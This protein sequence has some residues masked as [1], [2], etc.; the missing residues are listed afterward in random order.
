MLS[1]RFINYEIHLKKET[2]L[3]TKRV[4][5][6]FKK[7]ILI[8]KKYIDEMLKKK[9]IRLS[10]SSYI[11]LIFIVKKF[12]KEFKFYVNY[13]AFNALIVFNRHVSLL[14]KKTLIKLYI[15]RIYNKFDIIII[16]NEIRMKKD[17]KKKIV[18]LT[19]YDF[20]KYIIML[21]N[22]YNAFITFQTFINN[23]LRKYLNVFCTTYFDNIF[24]YNNI[25]K[26]HV[27]HVRKILKKL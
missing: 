7:Q 22:L 2:S 14:I 25:K 17:Y 15:I 3:S 26:K 13:R 18:F 1:N 27:F 16:F 6:I 24:I 9:Y 20:Y 4:Y 21:F 8:I 12:D 11:A 10:I 19:K 5:N 23:V